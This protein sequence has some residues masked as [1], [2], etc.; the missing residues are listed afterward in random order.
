M[1]WNKHVEDM[2]S[3]REV[4]F[5]PK[6]NYLVRKIIKFRSDGMIQIGNNK[7]HIN[8]WISRDKIFGKVIR[9]EK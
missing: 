1:N 4:K 6:G 8:G 3:G 5:R 7:G 2:K 9:V